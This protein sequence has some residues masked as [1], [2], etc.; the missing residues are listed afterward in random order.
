[1]FSLDGVHLTSRG[2]ALAANEFLK[3]IDETYGTNFE[4]SGNFAKAADYPT[5]YSPTLQ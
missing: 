3:A 4:E 1:M 5:N 2:Y